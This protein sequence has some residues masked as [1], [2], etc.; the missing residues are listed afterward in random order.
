MTNLTGQFPLE[1][2]ESWERTPEGARQTHSAFSTT[3]D[4]ARRD[5]ADELRL[6]GAKNPVLSSDIPLRNDGRPRADIA[7]RRIDDP[8]VALYFTL[9][10]E[11]MV[12]ARDS[13][14]SVHD[15]LRSLGLSISA[16]RAL[17]RHGGG[18]MLKRA[19]SGFTALPPPTNDVSRT[20]T[21]RPWR[22]VFEFSSSWDVDY[23]EVA[24]RYRLLAKKY[25]PDAG[26]SET[27]MAELNIAYAEAKKE[28]GIKV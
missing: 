2:P 16:M 12:M 19:F 14:W 24:L 11:Q 23:S 8:G 25:H 5:L 4:K 9:D 13:Y 26:G 18:H 20:Q 1:W 28:L 15:N 10:G 6:L 17:E 7:R 21:K 3:F 22:E 27:E